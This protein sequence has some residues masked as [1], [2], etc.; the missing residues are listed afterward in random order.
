[1]KV[2]VFGG[3]GFIGGHVIEE[4][5]SRG[6]D[7]VVFDR[8]K[9]ESDYRKTDAPYSLFL[10]DVTDAQA[11][12]E[13]MFGADG[14]I[15]LAGILGTSETVDNPMPSIMSNIVGGMNVLL[16]AR[17]NKVKGV[18]IT[19]GNH[20]MNNSYSISKT[21]QERF[22]LMFNKEHGTKIAVV[23]ALNAYGERQKHKPVRK[24]IPNFVTKA[25]RNEPITIYGSGNQI[26]DM[27]YVK[28]LA[29]I[30]VAALLNDHEVYDKIFEAGSGAKTSVNDIAE[31]VI[32]YTGSTGGVVHVPMRA[33]EIEDSVVLGDPKTLVPLFGM[34]VNL[35][36]MNEVLPQ[37]ISWYKD[38]YPYQ[39][40]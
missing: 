4:L 36:K 35:D 30:L 18:Q 2:V 23:R 28:D 3:L 5:V 7:V 13:V 26:M 34:P 33:G 27:I 11:V 19:V 39:E 1:M 16:A 20:F 31:M 38:K 14:F 40:D 9:S 12:D 21:T 10:G 24:I 37:V 15:N 17:R 32:K 6:C 22:T 8:W 25:L 29:V